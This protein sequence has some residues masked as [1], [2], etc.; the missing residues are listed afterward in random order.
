MAISRWL[1]TSDGQSGGI[2]VRQEC[3][4]TI[5]A[6]QRVVSRLMPPAGSPRSARTTFQ[7]ALS[8]GEEKGFPSGVI[9][10]RHSRQ[11]PDHSHRSRSVRR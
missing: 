5:Q 11:D 1:A 7:W 9:A 4:R 2:P 6:D 3:A 8:S 10:G